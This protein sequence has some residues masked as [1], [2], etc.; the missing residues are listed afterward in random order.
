MWG[1]GWRYFHRMSMGRPAK[2]KRSSFGER[3]TGARLRLG[4]TQT[5]IAGLIGVS[6]QTYAGWERRTTALKPEHMAQLIRVLKLNPFDFLGLKKHSVVSPVPEGRAYRLLLAV[7]KLPPK[8][9]GRILDLVEE[10][11]QVR[12]K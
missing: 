11:L 5:A 10:L 12:Q 9:Q 4:L 8:R 2:F 1:K 6:Q 7:S 3:L